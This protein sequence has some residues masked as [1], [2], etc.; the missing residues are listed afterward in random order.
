[1]A[2]LA[3]EYPQQVKV[4]DF[5][6]VLND[7]H[8]QEQMLRWL[9]VTEPVLVVGEVTHASSP[10]Q[11][12]ALEPEPES[13]PARHLDATDVHRWWQE[14]ELEEIRQDLQAEHQS[15]CGGGDNAAVVETAPD[16][17]EVSTAASSAAI[18]NDNAVA[19][20]SC[21]PCSTPAR[22]RFHC[23]SDAVA[24]DR[25]HTEKPLRIVDYELGFPVVIKEA[26]GYPVPPPVRLASRFTWLSHPYATLFCFNHLT[27]DGTIDRG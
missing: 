19:H 20:D 15:K 2:A 22:D 10:T 12:P 17:L 8:T 9:G 26:D 5:R 27:F 7:E 1:M 14:L 13:E 21:V 25:W 3:K 24:W 11:V 6:A 18:S 23:Y 4:W 16:Q